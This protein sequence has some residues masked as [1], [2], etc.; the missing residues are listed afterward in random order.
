M[1]RMFGALAFLLW[2]SASALA[3]TKDGGPAIEFDEEAHDFG[4]ITRGDGARYEFEFTNDG[5]ADLVILSLRADAGVA[6]KHSS[7]P[8]PPGGKGRITVIYDT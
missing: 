8:V 1:I 7:T 6:A 3:S 5:D 4:E 2:F